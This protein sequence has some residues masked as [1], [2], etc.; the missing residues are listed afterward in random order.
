MQT[1]LQY[2]SGEGVADFLDHAVGGSWNRDSTTASEKAPAQ[3]A[4]S[5]T[6][7]RMGSVGHEVWYAADSSFFMTVSYL[8]TRGVAAAIQAKFARLCCGH[9]RAL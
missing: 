2:R 9:Q 7:V 1:R 5:A 8:A 4:Y 6:S 3:L